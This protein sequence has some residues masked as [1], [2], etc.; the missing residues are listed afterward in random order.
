[1]SINLDTV[2]DEV[3]AI[4]AREVKRIL[5]ENEQMNDKGATVLQKL[6]GVLDDCIE[7]R[8]TRPPTDPF[9]EVSPT[10]LEKDFL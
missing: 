5:A 3:E 6:S 10:D 9:G 2:S 7:R 8:K 4:L 1:M